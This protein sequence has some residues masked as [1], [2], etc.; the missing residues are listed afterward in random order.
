VRQLGAVVALVALATALLPSQEPAP[1]PPEARQTVVDL[2]QII[3]DPEIW[4][5][6]PAL[7]ARDGCV[8]GQWAVDEQY[9]FYVCIPDRK[10]NQP[11]HKPQVWI[12]LVPDQTYIPAGY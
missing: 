2:D 6:P 11:G 3:S 10:H 4:S 12:R 8:V 1:E 5:Y 7:G 9:R